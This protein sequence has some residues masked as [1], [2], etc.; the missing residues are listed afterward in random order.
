MIPGKHQKCNKFLY[1][2][3]CYVKQV[4]DE[5]IIITR[6]TTK[7]NLS[8]LYSIENNH[9]RHPRLDYTRALW[10]A[11]Q[12]T[13]MNVESLFLKMS[14][15]LETKVF[16]LCQVNLVYFLLCVFQILKVRILFWEI[17]WMNTFKNEALNFIIYF[18]DPIY[19]KIR[20][21]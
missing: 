17:E 19:R 21:T 1:N 2:N 15:W 10:V 20:H 3:P 14:L 16:H 11:D 18:V 12:H 7:G 9:F 13:T 6:H 5:G 8:T 4:K